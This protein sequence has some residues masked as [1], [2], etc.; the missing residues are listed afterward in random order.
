MT[1]LVRLAFAALGPGPSL[2][3]LALVREALEAD[4]DACEV[5]REAQYG[6]DALHRLM[7]TAREAGASALVALDLVSGRRRDEEV[8][9]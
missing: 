4:P 5:L 3:E 1:D 2:R 8:E 6:G 9:L 7:E